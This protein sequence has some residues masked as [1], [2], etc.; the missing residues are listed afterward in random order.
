MQKYH[1]LVLKRT[2]N[3]ESAQLCRLLDCK[4]RIQCISLASKP[5]RC[6]FSSRWPDRSWRRFGRQG[7]AWCPR[8]KADGRLSH[9]REDVGL[10]Q[11]G[12]RR[13]EPTAGRAQEGGGGGGGGRGG[14]GAGRRRWRGRR[15]ARQREAGRDDERR[16]LSGGRRRSNRLCNFS[17][18][19]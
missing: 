4:L 19:M 6:P 18:V 9:G 11:Q 7:Q 3:T 5:S 12:L 14:G 10:P 1:F 15:E 16:S 8:Q 2:K 17:S 13:P